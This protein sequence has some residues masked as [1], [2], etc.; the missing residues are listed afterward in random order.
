MTDIQDQIAEQ[1]AAIRAK[2]A[3]DEAQQ[4]AY[5]VA[6]EARLA[7]LDAAKA[8]CSVKCG[9][10]TEAIAAA[11]SDEERLALN[12]LEARTH[13]EHAAD[14]EA[15][16]LEFSGQSGDESNPAPPGETAIDAHVAVV[17]EQSV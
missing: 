1:I 15:A 10:I 14:L 9:P 2:K 17:S 11:E 13:A 5:R 12:L 8:E 4:E 7:K 3:E 6:E 16:Y